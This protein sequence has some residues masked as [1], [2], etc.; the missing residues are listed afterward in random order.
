[1]KSWH[2]VG[3]RRMLHGAS[4]IFVIA[5]LVRLEYPITLENAL[6]QWISRFD[7]WQLFSQLRWQQSWPAWGWLPALTLLV[8]LGAG[9]VFCGWLCPLGWLLGLADQAGR[10]LGLQREHR[11]ATLVQL[12]YYW[13]GVV[14]VLFVAIS[15]WPV[16]LTPFA[17]LGHEVFRIL[18]GSIPWLL[19]VILTLTLVY[20]R[21]W[22][23]CLCPTGLI[24]A[25]VANWRSV[26]YQIDKRCTQCGKCLDVCGVGSA[27]GQA[28]N[29]FE[30]CL[31]CGKCRDQCPTQAI[32]W[33]RRLGEGVPEPSVQEQQ[34][35]R[36]TFLLVLGMFSLAAALWERTAQ[37]ATRIL[38]PPGAV[39]EPA[40]SAMCNRCG[41]C[42]QVC[43]AQAL[44]PMPVTA[45]YSNFETPCVIPRKARC[46]LCLAC[47]EVC[48]T[49]AIARVDISGGCMGT[50]KIQPER[51]IAWNDGKLCFICGEQCPVLAISGDERHR[52]TVSVEQCVG[53]GACENACPVAG[54][55]AI[56]VFP[57]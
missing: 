50:A 2:V 8:T 38:R 14:L 21:L 29:M 44:W 19:L 7:P 10:R 3:L 11:L 43:P 41:R 45:G 39:A 34:Y 6:L 54:E 31:V 16:F 42:I 56:Q 37:T 1:M 33:R 23:A 27:R 9:R 17:L 51:C 13:L 57:R 25:W 53:C 5:L 18:H 20:R 55:A 32:T 47:Q 35:S 48:P 28:G 46:D 24:L 15:N 12:R 40:F 30:G 4:A 36:R 49:G 52:P 26:S 22:C